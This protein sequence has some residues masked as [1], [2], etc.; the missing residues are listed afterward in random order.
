MR[1]V[2]ALHRV[3]EERADVSYGKGLVLFNTACKDLE[4]ATLAEYQ[5]LVKTYETTRVNLQMHLL[6]GVNLAHRLCPF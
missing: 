6:S 5:D 4:A 3:L 2:D 1:H